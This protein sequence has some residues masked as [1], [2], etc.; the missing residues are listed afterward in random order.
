MN[1][2]S[3]G[4]LLANDISDKIVEEEQSKI[5]QKITARARVYTYQM[6]FKVGVTSRANQ[7]ERQKIC[8]NFMKA[9]W[10]EVTSKTSGE[11]GERPGLTEY[12]FV[13][14]STS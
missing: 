9:G 11:C 14:H 10:Y 5:C 4:Y 13:R 7:S 3:P 1:K 12:K 2:L 8:D 6:I